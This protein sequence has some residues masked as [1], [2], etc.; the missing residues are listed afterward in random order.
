[1]EDSAA[2]YVKT[3]GSQ[4]MQRIQAY[5]VGALL[6]FGSATWAAI[7]AQNVSSVI[8]ILSI[9]SLLAGYIYGTVLPQYVW[10]MLTGDMFL[11]GAGV[12]YVWPRISDNRPGLRHCLL[13]FL[14]MCHDRLCTAPLENRK[15]E[16][17]LRL[18]QPHPS[19]SIE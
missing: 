9:P 6:M 19:L 1:M 16:P 14:R 18:T 10:G 15:S 2:E 7:Y 8:A 12:F 3:E 5:I 4:I 11:Y 17:F 13:H